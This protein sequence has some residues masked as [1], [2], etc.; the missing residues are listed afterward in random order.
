MDEKLQSILDHSSVAHEN[1]ASVEESSLEQSRMKLEKESLRVD[2]LIEQATNQAYCLNE[3][4]SELQKENVILH[5][6]LEM[7]NET[8]MLF[9]KSVVDIGAEFGGI[10]DSIG[11]VFG[12]LQKDFSFDLNDATSS[13]KIFFV[14]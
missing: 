10:L 6:K 5:E 1:V 4:M 3:T 9:R 13:G 12:T 7:V 11:N 8:E 14:Y 2:S